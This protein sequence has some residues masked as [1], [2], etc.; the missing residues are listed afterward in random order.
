MSSTV[1]DYAAHGVKWDLSALFSSLDDPKIESTWKSCLDG[2]NAFA[3]KYRDRVGML[4][5]ADLADAIK[6]FESLCNESSK[7]VHYAHLIF[8]ADTSVPAHG[9]FLQSQMEKSSEFRVKLMFFELELQKI[10][11][12]EME[13]LLTDSSLASYRHFITVLRASTPYMLSEPEEILLEETSNTGNRA[14]VRLHEEITANHIFHYVDPVSGESSEMTQ[15]EVMEL[16]RDPK[17]DVRQAAADSISKGMEELERVITFTY[18]TILADKSL[19]DRLRKLEYPERSR[20]M[21]NELDKSTVDLVMRLCKERADLV[22]RYYKVKAKILGIDQLSHIDRYAPLFETKEKVAWLDA[23]EMVLT[24]F[25]E[26]SEVLK[27]KAEEFFEKN[28]IDAEPRKGK[29]GGAF[30]NYNTPDTHPVMLMT[31]LGNLGDVSTLAHELGHCVHGSLSRKQT[32]LNFSGSLPLAELA[33]IFG[34]ILVFEKIVANAS[35]KDQLA[36][37]AEKIEGIFASVH[38]QSAMFRFE[39]RCHTQRREQGELSAEDFQSIW[40]EEMQSMFGS[41]VQLGDQHRRWWQYVGHFFFAPFYVY[42]YSFGELLTMSLYQQA[43]AEG[44][45]FADKYVEVLELGGSETPQQLM[46]R[47]GVDLASEAF[48]QGGFSVIESMVSK[49]EGLWSQFESSEA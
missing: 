4:G 27:D 9:A 31:Y 22:E 15:E 35:V 37:Y 38:R 18:N 34:E 17:R 47:L 16:L 26:F 32:L 20:H 7:P 43:Q 8:A 48:W 45:V 25:G 3:D 23:K 33:S 24:S 21:A 1:Q 28:W 5:A 40:Q 46:S 39:Q 36:L 49:F 41:S 29:G 14:W 2:A 30:C 6:E 13:Q 42:A 11:Q 44:P 12:E 19:E 10:P